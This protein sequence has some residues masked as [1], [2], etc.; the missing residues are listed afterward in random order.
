MELYV[1]KIIQSMRK[2][3]DNIEGSV[4]FMLFCFRNTFKYK[5]IFEEIH[6]QSVTR[7]GYRR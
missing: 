1:Q 4:S 5:Q 7:D 6:N 2:T 3:H